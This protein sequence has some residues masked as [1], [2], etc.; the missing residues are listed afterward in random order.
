MGTITYLPPLRTAVALAGTLIV[1]FVLCAIV[2]AILPGPQFSHMW[3]QLFTAAPLGTVQAWIEGIIASVIVGF[4]TGYCF[5]H[6][7]NW[8]GKHFKIN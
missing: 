3:L 7:Y 2:Q 8:S 4:I 5:G 1:A 6:C